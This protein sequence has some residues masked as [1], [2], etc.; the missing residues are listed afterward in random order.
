MTRR[1]AALAT[2]AAG[3]LAVAGPAT[4][5]SAAGAPGSGAVSRLLGPGAQALRTG[6]LAGRGRPADDDRVGRP[7]RI[8]R[9]PAVRGVL[10]RAGPVHR[11]RAGHHAQREEQPDPG[12]A[13][14][15]DHVGGAG[16]AHPADRRPAGRRRWRPACPARPRTPAWPRAT[17]TAR[18]ALRLLGEGWNGRTWTAQP[19]NKQPVAVIPSGISCTWAK[20]CVAV[21]PARPAGPPWPSTGTAGSGPC[22]PPSRT[23]CWSA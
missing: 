14:E 10:H 2:I 15:R 7:D 22:W 9:G 3:L 17:P 12:R 11:D 1:A 21:G 8:H 4:V 6:G 5:A 23:A 20:D 18:A 16:H 19:L 13:V